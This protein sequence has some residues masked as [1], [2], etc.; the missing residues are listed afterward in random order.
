MSA[1][2]AQVDSALQCGDPKLSTL[3]RVRGSSVAAVITLL[4]TPQRGPPTGGI[5]EQE[6]PAEET[7]AQASQECGQGH[8]QV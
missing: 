7:R 6:T 4:L 2:S 8:A 1:I 5:R 3:T